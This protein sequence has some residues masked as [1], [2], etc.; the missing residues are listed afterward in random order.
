MEALQRDA[1][2]LVPRSLARLLGEREVQVLEEARRF[3]PE[4]SQAVAADLA[5][6]RWMLH[7]DARYRSEIQ[8]V[9]LF[10]LQ[11]PAAYWIFNANVQ[12][13]VTERVSASAKVNNLLDE[14]YEELARYRMP[15]RNWMFGVSYRL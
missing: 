12:C 6:G 3:P 14:Q 1:R 13:H 15:G 8:E 4:L 11:A 7:G 10:P 9:F 5:L 2:R